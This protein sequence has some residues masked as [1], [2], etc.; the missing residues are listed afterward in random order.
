VKPRFSL[1]PAIH[2]RLTLVDFLKQTMQVTG[3]LL[4]EFSKPPPS[5]L[6]LVGPLMPD[7]G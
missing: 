2:E 3:I 6:D 5:V 4:R 7:Q 1:T